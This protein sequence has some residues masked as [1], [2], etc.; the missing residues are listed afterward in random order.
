[1][2]YKIHQRALEISNASCCSSIE[3]QLQ[4]TC[5]SEAMTT[6]SMFEL[7]QSWATNRDDFH[8][9]IELGGNKYV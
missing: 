8:A 3:P 6:Q 9:A 5:W 4:L 2:R 1:M 7:Q